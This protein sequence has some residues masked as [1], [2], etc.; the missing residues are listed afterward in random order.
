MASS[1]RPPA[2]RAA[3]GTN[4]IIM[5]KRLASDDAGREAVD[6]FVCT[7]DQILAGAENNSR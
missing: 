5:P 6:A 2:A 4:L 7:L 3:D 1:A